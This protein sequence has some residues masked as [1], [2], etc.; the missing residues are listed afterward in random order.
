MLVATDEAALYVDGRWERAEGEPLA[1][2]NP[3]T[4]EVLATVSSATDDEVEA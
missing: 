3:A 1:V 4:E 2:V